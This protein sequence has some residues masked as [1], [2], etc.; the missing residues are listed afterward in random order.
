MYVFFD[1][2]EGLQIKKDT[3]ILNE[4][5]LRQLD[6]ILAQNLEKIDLKDIDE[7]FEEELFEL[8][9]LPMNK[10]QSSNTF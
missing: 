1:Y 3:A 7:E 8:D 2:A 10:K 9:S 4:S 5:T 6:Q